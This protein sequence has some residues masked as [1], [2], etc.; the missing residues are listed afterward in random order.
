MRNQLL[1]YI[2]ERNPAQE[3]KITLFLKQPRV[4][5]ELDEFL[6]SYAGYM[7]TSGITIYDL[8]D[9]YLSNSFFDD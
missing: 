8:A 6:I 2:Y 7:S 1:N 5:D 9:A 3:K 4:L